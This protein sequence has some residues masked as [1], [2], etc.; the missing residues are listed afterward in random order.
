MTL[1]LYL[2]PLACLFNLDHVYYLHSS[3]KPTGKD[4]SFYQWKLKHDLC[5]PRQVVLL[6]VVSNVHKC[7]LL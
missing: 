6:S 7:Y 1:V 3:V 5:D 4:P 2:S